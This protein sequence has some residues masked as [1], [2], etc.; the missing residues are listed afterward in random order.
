MRTASIQEADTL[1]KW[2]S[3]VGGL[4]QAFTSGKGPNLIGHFWYVFLPHL[5]DTTF[6]IINQSIN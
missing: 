6:G 4:H 1:L 5:V 2:Q 3:S